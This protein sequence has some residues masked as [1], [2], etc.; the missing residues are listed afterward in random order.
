MLGKGESAKVFEYD[1]LGNAV[2]VLDP[3]T[4]LIDAIDVHGGDITKLQGFFDT[5]G[6]KGAATFAKIYR[7]G[8]GKAGGGRKALEEKF[9][10]YRETDGSF[11]ELQKDAAVMQQSASVKMSQAVEKLQMALGSEEMLDAAVALAD[12]AKELAPALSAF[13]KDLATILN[14]TGQAGKDSANAAAEWEGIQAQASGV[15]ARAVARRRSGGGMSD[16]EKAQTEKEIQAVRARRD[17]LIKTGELDLGANREVLAEL[18]AAAKGQTRAEF[19]KE[20]ASSAVLG[21]FQ[22]GAPLLADAIRRAASESMWAAGGKP[23][24]RSPTA[25]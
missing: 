19:D 6:M 4:A 5:E 7:E 13:A 25:S 22:L 18:G 1:K 11:A 17:A 2:S 9:R 21:G 3:I 15:R 12:A 8:G 23:P 16:E 20:A 24:S 14:P 10:E